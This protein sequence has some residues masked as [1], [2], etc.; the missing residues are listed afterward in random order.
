MKLNLKKIFQNNYELAKVQDNIFESLKQIANHP[1]L[2][3]VF[4]DDISLDTNDAIIEHKLARESK[5]YL[6]ITKDSS[7][8]IYT[9]A[10]QNK[11][12]EK[13]IIL[14]ASSAVNADL[15]FF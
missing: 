9:S 4:I 2:N 6:V 14:K 13:F 3:G 7:A 12:P 8:N 15:Y 1:L 11:Q 5:G 10:T